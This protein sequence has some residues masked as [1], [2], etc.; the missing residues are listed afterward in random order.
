MGAVNKITDLE[1]G[2][3]FALG[4]EAAIADHQRQEGFP[5]SIPK[6]ASFGPLRRCWLGFAAH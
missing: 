2:G 5:P 4:L 1:L 3:R 6:I